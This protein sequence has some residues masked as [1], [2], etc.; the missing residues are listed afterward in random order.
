MASETDQIHRAAIEPI[1]NNSKS[2]SGIE[3]DIPAA[4]SSSNMATA[5]MADKT[6]PEIVNY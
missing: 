6:T 4:S 2:D 1:I 5:K 3:S